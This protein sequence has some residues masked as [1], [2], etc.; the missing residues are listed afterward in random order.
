MPIDGLDPS[1][2]LKVPQRRRQSSITELVIGGAN[3]VISARGLVRQ[4]RKAFV[5]ARV[6]ETDSPQ[7]STK[8][9]ALGG[10]SSSTRMC[11]SVRNARPCVTS[12]SLRPNIWDDETSRQATTPVAPGCVART[13]YLRRYLSVVVLRTASG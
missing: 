10:T 6:P 3:L 8:G 7:R 1:L 9:P 13:A 12:T 4:G 11:Q 5:E 2:V